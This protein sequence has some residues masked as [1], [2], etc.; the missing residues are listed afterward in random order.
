MYN[1]IYIYTHII[2]YTSVHKSTY[3]KHVFFQGEQHPTASRREHAC[4]MVAGGGICLVNYSPGFINSA[5]WQWTI[6]HITL[7]VFLFS[8]GNIQLWM[9]CSGNST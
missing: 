6:P 8:N 9:V 1:C 7:D 2:L 3:D 5:I 4:L